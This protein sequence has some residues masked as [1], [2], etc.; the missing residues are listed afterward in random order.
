[1]QPAT[2]ADAF[3]SWQN[4]ETT[5]D[6]TTPLNTTNIHSHLVAPHGGKLIDLILNPEQAAD[7]KAESRDF[8]SWDLTPR[9]ICDLELLLN[10]GFSPLAGFMNKDDY[11]SVCDNMH[12]TNGTLWPMPITLDVTEAFAKTLQP[13]STR[14]ALRDPEGVM[15][16]ILQVEDVWQP[17]RQA[18]AKSVFKTASVAHPGV[19]YLM[20]RSNPCYVGG[21]LEGLQLP[22]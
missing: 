2:E 10:G 5:D 9:Q 14:V 8:P 12:L 4:N 16:A 22:S 13:G 15:I 21:R 11:E 17:D 7:K 20:N 6:S 19:A 18:E 1:M 3:P